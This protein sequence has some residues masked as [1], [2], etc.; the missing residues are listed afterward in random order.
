MARMHSRGR[1]VSGSTKPKNP[2]LSMVDYEEEEIKDLITKLADEDMMPSEIGQELRDRYGIPD[3]KAVTGKS[4]NQILEK[5][6][7]ALEVPED[8]YKLMEKAIQIREHLERNKKDME[9][10][11]S[12][13]LT[14]SKIR[15]LVKYYRGDKLPEDWK[16]S[17]DKARLYVK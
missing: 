9:A 6:E 12:L 4:I 16:Y 11:R 3:V 10:K 1:G 2:D 8:L 14:E 5:E 15:R 7:V 13:S 17:I